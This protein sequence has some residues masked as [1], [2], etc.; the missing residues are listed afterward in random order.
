[1][2]IVAVEPTPGKP[3]FMRH[4]YH[5]RDCGKDAT[6]DVAKK[7]VAAKKSRR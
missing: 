2:G 1:M 3:R 5:C 4:T 7:A 6:F